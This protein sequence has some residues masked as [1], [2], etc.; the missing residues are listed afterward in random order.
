MHSSLHGDV[1]YRGLLRECSIVK[2]SWFT[3]VILGKSLGWNEVVKFTLWCSV[4]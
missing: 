1:E 2:H 4:V 3:C